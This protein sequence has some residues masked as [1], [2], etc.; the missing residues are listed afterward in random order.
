MAVAVAVASL[1]VV[2]AACSSGASSGSSSS[3]GS[4]SASGP[5]TSSPAR[6][7][8]TSSTGSVSTGSV[9]SGTVSTGS[10]AAGAAGEVRR[11]QVR[12]G[13]L[14][15]DVREQGPVD[16]EPVLLLHGFP[17]TSHEWRHQQEALAAAGYRTIAPDQRGYSP[18]ARPAEVADYRLDLLVDDVLGLADAMGVDRFHLVGHDWG[19]AV[20]WATAAKAPDRLRSLTAV[21]VPHLAAYAEAMVDPAGEQSRKSGYIDTFLAPGA[22]ERL[23]SPSFF[24]VAFSKVAAPDDIAEYRKVLGTPEAMAAALRW[25]AANDPRH[26]SGPRLGPVSV[27]TLFVYGTADCCLGRDAADA[28]GDH[29]TGPY[30]YVVL[31]GVSHWVPEE[32]A[33]RLDRL[34]LA[35]LADPAAAG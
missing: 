20:A 11:S 31:D 33:D 14:T 15:F 8:A 16:G 30:R 22:A 21:S 32:A 24:D 13:D 26:Q 5:A 3:S 12:V 28:T 18:G 7:A 34:L 6:P 35:H 9:T 2:L 10:A 25:Y 17:Q 23:S 1:A 19:A 29:V 27:P 4:G